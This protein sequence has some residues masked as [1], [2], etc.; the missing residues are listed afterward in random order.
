M[1][2]AATWPNCKVVFHKS[3]M[4]LIID[5]DMSYGSEPDA[6]SRG[7]TVQYLGRLNN[8]IFVNGAIDVTSRILP[9]VV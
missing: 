6:R 4:Q 9:T 1:N 2:Y 5:A 7:G 3:D 8:R